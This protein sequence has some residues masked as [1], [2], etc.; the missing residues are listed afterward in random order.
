[1]SNLDEEPCERAPESSSAVGRVRALTASSVTADV[2]PPGAA[3][4]PFPCQP[5]HP[6][7]MRIHRCAKESGSAVLQRHLVMKAFT[8][9]KMPG[10]PFTVRLA[11]VLL[12]RF[13]EYPPNAY[14]GVQVSAGVQTG[15]LMAFG[16][17]AGRPPP[18]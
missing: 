7:I 9:C 18:G 10:G 14:C 1:M 15:L 13:T 5:A 12:F 4:N 11:R 17:G 2:G 6:K 3:V 8:L 16:V